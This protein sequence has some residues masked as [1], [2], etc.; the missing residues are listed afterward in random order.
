MT[1]RV[2][3]SPL[4][5][6]A[7][8][9]PQTGAD[10]LEE[11]IVRAGES[12]DL[13]FVPYLDRGSTLT[14]HQEA[15]LETSE[16]L[17]AIHLPANLTTIAPNLRWV[18]AFGA[19]VEHL[20]PALRGSDVWLTT[21]AGVAA[22]GI[23][24]FVMA[25]LLEVWKDLREIERLQSERT[26]RQHT[27]RLVAGKVMGILGLGAIGTEI[28]RRA[29]AFDM[30]I[31]AITRTVT[32]RVKPAFVDRLHP[33]ADLL[34][35]LPG[36]DAFVVTAPATSETNRMIGARELAALPPGAIFCNVSRGGLVDETALKEALVTGRLG[37]A[38]LDVTQQEPLASDDPLWSAPRLFL[39]PH[40]SAS[41]DRY[42]ESLVDL[43]VDNLTHYRRG[44]P[45]RNRVD[46]ER[47]Y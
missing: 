39:S 33:T 20:L 1:A 37:A 6:V 22:P 21:A 28:A 16:V 44:T 13:Q 23:S 35:V 7:L 12:I 8:Y 42:W 25:R 15:V 4:R 17:L 41:M 5:V 46:L 47:G 36:L 34:R 43:F 24:E 40:S 2:G 10:L 3:R 14:R 38:V 45:L 31:V 9:V 19:G 26:W 30:E 27:G 18:Q 32:G 29:K 11:R